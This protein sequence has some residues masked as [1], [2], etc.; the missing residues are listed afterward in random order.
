[1]LVV[2]CLS[3]AVMLFIGLN[4]NLW[5]TNSF[6]WCIMQLKIKEAQYVIYRSKD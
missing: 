1:M 5:L 2:I 3:M 4:I 6:E